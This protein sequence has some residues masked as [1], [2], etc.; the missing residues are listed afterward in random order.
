M[1]LFYRKHTRIV[2]G[3]GAICDYSLLELDK[4]GDNQFGSVPEGADASPLERLNFGK[5]EKSFLNFKQTYTGLVPDKTA[6]RFQDTL[7]CYK[8]IK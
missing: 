6:H 8:E 2:D 5:L 1:I 4:Y 7:S 3:I